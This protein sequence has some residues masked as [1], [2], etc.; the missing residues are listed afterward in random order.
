MSFWK[1]KTVVI[2]GHTGF[3]GSWLSLFLKELGANVYGYSLKPKN[4]SLFKVAQIDKELE[5]VY[6]DIRNFEKVEDFLNKIQPEILFHLA[7]QP[8]V[9]ESYLNPLETVEVNVLGSSN[10]L[11]AAKNV[12]SIKS[13]VN[14]TT[15]K[16]YDNKEWEWPYRENDPLGGNDPYS[17]SKACVEIMNH[18]FI[19]SFFKTKGVGLATA[20]AGNVI[21]GGDWAKNRVVPDVLKAIK[22]GE[23]VSL[24]YPNST[25]PWQHVLDPLNGYLILAEKLFISPE[26]HSHP[27]NFGPKSGNIVTVK[28]LVESLLEAFGQRKNWEYQT[29]DH[30]HESVMLNLDSSRSRI[31]LGWTPKW[32]LKDTYESIVIWYKN[33][34]AGEN[35]NTVTKDQIKKFLE[36]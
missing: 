8:L 22:K 25:R 6:G 15:D 24:R 4:L 23:K 10:I 36:T 12:D 21:G 7:A 35:M 9:K 29:K 32:S 16:C 27:Y 2:T 28:N 14:V 26:L 1:N 3:K 19:Q 11:M 34:E 17:A 13:I 20:R 31:N 33:Y 18:S 5:S 30:S